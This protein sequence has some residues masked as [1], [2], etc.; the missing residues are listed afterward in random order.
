MNNQNHTHLCKFIFRNIALSVYQQPYLPNLSIKGTLWPKSFTNLG[1]ESTNA[2]LLTLFCNLS[3]TTSRINYMY[4]AISY[5]DERMFIYNYVQDKYWA[6]SSIEKHAYLA[7]KL[8]TNGNLII[9]LVNL[10]SIEFIS[11]LIVV[12]KAGL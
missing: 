9:S 3:N 2:H 7:F 8:V 1:L 10:Y 12:I 11:Y 5:F 4:I 6:S